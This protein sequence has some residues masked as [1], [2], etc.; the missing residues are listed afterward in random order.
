MSAIAPA[1]LSVW[2]LAALA[3]IA[4]R[5]LRVS[6]CPICAGVAGTWAWM[7]VGRHFGVSVDTA[8]LPLLM[9]GSVVGIAYQLERSLPVG[10]SGALWKSV[11]IPLGL[12]TAYALEQ[13]LWGLLVPMLAALVAAS[14]VFFRPGSQSARSSETVEELKRQMKQCC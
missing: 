1:L 3:W 4:R 13:S 12:A 5:R 8:M 14:A 2:L 6:V 9:A 10:R 7:L 11:A